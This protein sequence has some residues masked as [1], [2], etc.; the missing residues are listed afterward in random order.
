MTTL[1]ISTPREATPRS[2]TGS[3]ARTLRRVHTYLGILFAPALL[4]FA[5]TGAAQVVNLH[6]AGVRPANPL[7]V[8]LASIHKKQAFDPRVAKV[9]PKSRP[10]AKSADKADEARAPIT[11]AVILLKVFALGAAFSLA[12]SVLTGLYMSFKQTRDRPLYSL[13]LVAG[14]A[15][16]LA[17]IAMLH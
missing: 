1:S 9:E 4:F 7:I 14:F 3:T 15:L 5:L 11:H 12:V 6:K 16:P 2:K 13:L 10:S 17:A 8:Q